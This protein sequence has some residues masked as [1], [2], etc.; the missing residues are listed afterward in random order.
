MTFS[1]SAGSA[2]KIEELVRRYPKKEAALLPVLH[3]IQRDRGYISPEAEEWAAA[4]LG[5]PP[6]RVR[7]VLS[8][9]A[10]LRRKPAGKYVIQVCRNISCFLAGSEDIVGHL[11]SK[12]GVK[13]GET[14]ADGKFTLL[15]VECL[16]N[17]DHAPC[18]MVNDDDHGPV[19]KDAVDAILKGLS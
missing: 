6:L 16:G 1:L 7:E 17:C 14:T 4:T 15:A 10:L 13:P 11:E 8:F 5:L 18:L 12:L 9:Y 19:S 3:V 2:K